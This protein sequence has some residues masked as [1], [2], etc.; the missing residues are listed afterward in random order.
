[1]RLLSTIKHAMRSLLRA[2]QSSLGSFSLYL[3]Y[4][5]ARSTLVIF[6]PSG[7]VKSSLDGLFPKDTVGIE[8]YRLRRSYGRILFLALEEVMS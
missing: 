1:M 8:P 3:G 4:C 5:V 6:S 7:I 2:Q